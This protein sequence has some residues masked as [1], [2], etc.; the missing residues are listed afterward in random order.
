MPTFI[1]IT[2]PTPTAPNP[3][4]KYTSTLPHLQLTSPP[5][6]PT[7]TSITT[8]TPNTPT[9]HTS[10]GAPTTSSA[11]KSPKTLKVP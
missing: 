5:T 9:K 7:L 10:A 6:T 11:P 2:T 4:T 3:A 8:P 1:P